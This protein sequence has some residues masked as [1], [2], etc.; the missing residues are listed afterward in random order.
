MRATVMAGVNIYGYVYAESGVGQLT[1]L[2]IETLKGTEIQ[3][4]V[5]PFSATMSRQNICIDDFGVGRPVFDINII[6]V[7]A[8]QVPVFV[9]H[10]GPSCLDGRYS[11]GIWAWEIEEFPNWMAK[12]AAYLD[13]IWGISSF[14]AKAIASKV[15]VPVYSFTLPIKAPA[16]VTKS[17]FELG[18]PESF[19]YLYCFD[20]DSVF[21]RKNPLAV[22]D[23]FTAAFPEPAGAHLHL[24]SINGDRHRVEVERV[25]EAVAGRKD[26][27]YRDGYSTAEG[28]DSLMK[29][30]DA[31]VSLH[32]AEG[33]GL[34]MA[35]A[36]A[37]GKPVIA[38]GYSGNL[39]FMS[40]ANSYLV[41]YRMASIGPRSSPYPA[42]GI[43]AEPDVAEAARLI[44]RVY[45]H[46]AEARQKGERAKRDIEL[47][48]SPGARTGFVIERI[49][50]ARKAGAG[51]AATGL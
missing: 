8:D 32:R 15:D 39:D 1:R 17:R 34:T 24:K 47:L 7:N 19:L 9:E 14:T 42:D 2:L 40:D 48:H 6:G 46:P 51:C 22:V 13:E 28:Q 26:I 20:L 36:M 41:P 5:I 4:S 23:A 12:S 45:V 3:Y 33:Y 10:Y 21:A 49:S 30:C 11:I 27:T 44:R 50:S 31:Y 16:P 18:L 25:L 37:L 38:T 29:S 35:E 43:W